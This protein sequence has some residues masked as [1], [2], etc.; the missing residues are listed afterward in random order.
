MLVKRAPPPRTFNRAEPRRPTRA[1]RR[2]SDSTPPRKRDRRATRPNRRLPRA[3]LARRRG[4]VACPPAPRASNA[5]S[6]VAL[7]ASTLASTSSAPSISA[8]R[9][10]RVVI[11]HPPPRAPAGPLLHGRD[12]SDLQT[13]NRAEPQRP[14]APAASKSLAKTYDMAIANFGEPLYGATLRSLARPNPAHAR[15]PTPSLPAQIRRREIRTSEPR[16][17]PSFSNSHRS[18][19]LAYP[20]SIDASYRTGCQPFVSTRPT[21]APR[22][23]LFRERTN[24][25]RPGRKNP[26]SRSP[27][28]PLT[29]TSSPPPRRINPPATSSRNRPAPAPPSSSSTA[30]GARSPIRRITRN[31]RVP[32][33]SSSLTTS[34]SPS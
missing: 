15:D 1:T 21:R 27:D 4:A 11:S 16:L 9:R 24:R 8:T 18:G 23:V 29:R 31:P 5:I 22:V 32:T 6:H 19:G 30:E 28:L 3:A 14:E 2:P 34:T 10:G 12:A 33:P 17:T 13:F 20:T 26:T 7:L 25:T